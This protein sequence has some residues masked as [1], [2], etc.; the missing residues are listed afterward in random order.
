M[1]PETFG[2]VRP[3]LKDMLVRREAPQGR[4]MRGMAVGA[5][6]QLQIRSKLVVAVVVVARDSGVLDSAVHP[7]DLTVGS[8]MVELGQAMLDAV[9]SLNLRNALRRDPRC[10]T[11]KQRAAALVA[12]AARAVPV[13]AAGLRLR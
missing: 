1:E 6:E 7:P 8:R 9:P 11:L 5:N 4:R 3:D 13:I 2:L 10:P 12:N